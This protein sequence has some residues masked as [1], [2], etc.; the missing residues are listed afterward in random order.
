MTKS[1]KIFLF[2][3]SCL[4]SSAIATGQ[5]F[6]F[7]CLCAQLT[8]DSCDLCPTNTALF[9]RSFK[10]LLIYRN[11]NPY[12]WIDSP[13]TSRRLKNN[14]IQFIEQIPNPDQV[15]IALFQTQFSTMQGFVDSTYCQC[16]DVGTTYTAGPGIV[17]S[18]DTISAVDTS[19]TNEL[20]HID[21]LLILSGSLY[22]SL[23]DDGVPASVVVLPV[24]DG[25]E[26]KVNA[27]T[28][29]SVTGIGTIANPYVVTNTGDLSNTNELQ[30]YGHAGT[31]TY[32]NTLS[33]GG[34][35]WSITG[36]GI[37]VISQ[38]GGAITVTA[39][40]VDG[41]TT[42]E[43]QT[44][45]HAGTTTYTNTLSGGGGSF[46]LQASGIA[47]IS[48]SGGTVTISA[49]E[50]DGSVTNEGVI[51]VGAG[52]A[53]S[54]VITSTTSGATGVTVNVAGILSISEST[55]SN[56]GSITLTATEVDGSTSNELQTY[57]HAGTTTYTNTLSS[58]GGSWS[59]TGAGIAV[60]SQTG[61]AITVTATEVDGSTSNELQTYGHSGT[62]SYTNT[63]SSGGG[64]F[65]LQASGIASISH[66]GGTVT[67]SAT[68]VDG[69][70]TN[71]L[72][73]Y[74]HA[75]TTTYTN[76]LSGGGGSWSITGA[77]IAVISQTGG[78]ITVTATEVDGSVTNEGI[79]G[80]G[81]G[82]A[83]SSVITS[84]TSG[85]TGVTVNVSGILSISES[86]A[87]NGGSITLTATEVDGSTT[88]EVQTISASG[89]G[90]TSYNIDLN[91]SGGSV[92]V[93]EGSGIDLTRS[94]NTI[95]IAA[96]G[97]TTAYVN[98]GNSF[99]ANATIGLND[100]F[101]WDFK[102]N[103]LV[104]GGINAGGTWWIG[105]TPLTT[106]AFNINGLQGNG[107][108]LIAGGGSLVGPDFITLTGS[109][110]GS[111]ATLLTGAMSMVNGT[112][113]INAENTSSTGSGGA[114][115][116][117]VVA[118][119][120]TGDPKFQAET[121]TTIWTWGIDNSI[122]GEP[123]KLRPADDIGS[124]ALGVTVLVSGFTGVNQAA[125]VQELQ[126]TG[127][128]GIGFPRGTTAQRLASPTIPI[129]RANNEYG[130]TEIYDPSKGQ[131]Y[132]YSCTSSPTFAVG[133]SAGTGASAGIVAG[134]G[135]NDLTG[136]F[137]VTTGTTPGTGTY[138]T[139]TF[140]FAFD[141][142]TTVVLIT[143]AN[144]AAMTASNLWRR[145]VQSNTGFTLRGVGLPASTTFQFNYQVMQ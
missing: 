120:S 12:K 40:E 38:T 55:A 45:G 94:G 23:S 9:S 64:A 70:T 143:P 142:T 69:S 137:S 110:S 87:S 13:Y 68:E 103:N 58:G 117:T 15:T 36:A 47:S 52:G 91:L 86:T 75:G 21:T 99:G 7:E 129:I 138:V 24:P 26:T 43:L 119:A 125:P 73:T 78:A 140:S 66:S 22:V 104:R 14:T 49:T 145:D 48:N 130:G 50:V 80:V 63:L 132:R 17:I 97:S 107:G 136:V 67:I 32:T 51:G 60:I 81:A 54:S 31:T 6:T 74:G 134:T 28:G 90:P 126:V 10:G 89:A 71:E 116:Q 93:A 19:Y 109:G 11:G 30:T 57:G 100:N 18:N 33:S 139:A 82:G 65:T 84:T 96:T 2:V 72:Q 53:S 88:N 123:W 5:T 108:I 25:S 41:S 92:T 133:A 61:G 46:T 79:I 3:L 127:T 4:F 59:I 112:V 98:G 83:S 44:Y 135:S 8:G 144:D 131:W 85:A 105:A 29:I 118:G 115:I 27:G 106:A 95:T 76:T 56:G 111:D 113:L 34:G 102:T 124:T 20:Q 77:G 141:G 1:L 39:T 122:A 114:V 62:T 16:G 37:A 42:N 35:S 128:G 121:A 101:R